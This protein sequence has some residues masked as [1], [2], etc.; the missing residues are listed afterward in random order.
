MKLMRHTLLAGAFLLLV[1]VCVVSWAFRLPNARWKDIRPGMSRFEIELLLG[2]NQV[3]D[4]G[5][6]GVTTWRV[7]S[8]F[9]HSGVD[10]YHDASDHEKIVKVRVHRWLKPFDHYTVYEEF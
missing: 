10:L 3:W 6:K 7:D 1:A 8:L 4:D 5:A 2:D 9:F